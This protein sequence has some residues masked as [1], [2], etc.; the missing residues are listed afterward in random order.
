MFHIDLRLRSYGN[1]LETSKTI[2]RNLVP[3][4]IVPVQTSRPKINTF[5]TFAENQFLGIFRIGMGTN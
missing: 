1:W 5:G 2:N 3:N 4:P